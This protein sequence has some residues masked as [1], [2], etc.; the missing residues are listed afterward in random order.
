MYNY[1]AEEHAELIFIRWFLRKDVGGTCQHYPVDPNSEE[2]HNIF[3]ILCNNFNFGVALFDT[4]F[5]LFPEQ[6]L[7]FGI[8]RRK[9]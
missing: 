2:W 3:E 7:C 6:G 8:K 5:G 9:K 1:T 4:W